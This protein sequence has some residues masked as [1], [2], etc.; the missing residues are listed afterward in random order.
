MK[1]PLLLEFLQIIPKDKVVTYKTLSLI[2]G[3]HPREIANILKNNQQQDVY[4]CYKVINNDGTVWGYNLGVKEKIKRLADDG[5]YLRENKIP[6]E[7][8][9][10]PELFNFFVAFALPPQQQD[11][12]ESAARKLDAHLP[13]EAANIQLRSPHITLRF[14]GNMSLQRFHQ[15]IQTTQKNFKLPQIKDEYKQIGNFNER[16]RFW[17]PEQK[18]FDQRQ[19]IYDQYHQAIGFRPEP[20]PYHPHLTILRA[21]E[22]FEDYKQQAL[23]IIQQYSFEIPTS[24]LTFYAAVDNIYQ[25]PLIELDQD[26]QD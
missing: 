23:D 1:K 13:P 7:N 26:S 11:K 18:N 2:F 8:I 15:I 24:K 3:L 14:F 17:Q 4:P 10:R 12:F 22:E 21:K 25:V 19:K 20:R 9:R 6:R 16:V 5:I